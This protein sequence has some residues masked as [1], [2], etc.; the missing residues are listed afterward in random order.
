MTTAVFGGAQIPLIVDRFLKMDSS[1]F[2]SMRQYFEDFIAQ[3]ALSE[4]YTDCFLY[5]DA[6][7]E[8]LK[9]IK[10]IENPLD[11]SFFYKKFTEKRSYRKIASVNI[12]LATVTPLKLLIKKIEKFSS[13]IF[14]GTDRLCINVH[15][16]L[17][18]S[19][20]PSKVSD[21]FSCNIDFMRSKMT[22]VHQ[23]LSLIEGSLT[24]DS[25][26]L[27]SSMTSSGFY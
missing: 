9:E 2:Y 27:S 17:I 5:V 1:G 22:R 26:K 3:A 25:V 10:I 16:R 11:G 20:A 12:N 24:A 4:E 23:A 18:S 6:L 8:S 13:E 21:G 14:Y 19:R 7:G 15:L